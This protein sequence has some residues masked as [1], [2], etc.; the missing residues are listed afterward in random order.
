MKK[1]L[2][3]EF[4]IGVS[5]IIAILILIYGID[6]L[7]GINV[8]KPTNYYVA[9]YENVMGLEVSAPITIDGY[10]VGVVREINFN[11]ENPGKIEVVL[12]V[13]KDL[14]LPADSYAEIATTMLSG[15]YINIH[16]GKDKTMIPIGGEIHSE[17]VPDMMASLQNDML[18]GLSKVVGHVDT[19]VTNLNTLVSDP[20]L[21]ATIRSLDGISGNLLLASGGLNNTLNHDIP[22]MMG[23]VHHITTGVDT[24]V[25]NLMHL[26]YQLKNLPL[27][28]TMANVEDVTRNLSEFS[29]QL[30]NRESTLGKL[31]N[32]PA[33]YNQLHRVSADID[34][35][36]IDIKRNPKRYISIKLL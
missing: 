22:R 27:E 13:D 24:V 32:D 19:L 3:R 2:T 31:M 4:K 35:L 17:T 10:K 26:S 21:G 33:L 23:N 25:N 11:Y 1:I 12:A 30:N 15:A 6:Y 28:P 16:M 18:P 20:A 8:F 5:V 29:A 7:K 9:H 34:S 36:I 14:K